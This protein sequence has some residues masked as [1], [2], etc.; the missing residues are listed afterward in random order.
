MCNGEW[1]FYS[2]AFKAVI[3]SLGCLRID[4][5]CNGN[6]PFILGASL[7]PWFSHLGA[8]AL[9]AREMFVVGWSVCL[10]WFGPPLRVSSWLQ[11]RG[12]VEPCFSPLWLVCASL[13]TS[14]LWFGYV[15]ANLIVSRFRRIFWVSQFV[16]SPW[17]C[18][19]GARLL[20]GRFQLYCVQY[21]IYGCCDAS[22]WLEAWF[23]PLGSL[24][25][26]VALFRG[27]SSSCSI[28]LTLSL[29]PQLSTWNLRI[30]ACS[31]SENLTY[32]LLWPVAACKILLGSTLTGGLLLP[33]I[34]SWL[35]KPDDVLAG[36]MAPFWRAYGSGP[37]VPLFVNICMIMYLLRLCPCPICRASILYA[38]GWGMGFTFSFS[39]ISRVL[40]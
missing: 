10:V 2:G 29:R 27:P 33:L 28:S 5:V 35:P 4:C 18:H 32:W 37:N 31:C 14:L 3:Q 36:Q 15:S 23:W 11:W 22:R 8:F 26:A 1:P 7:R 25:N 16:S 20:W 24:P 30:Q 17:F 12:S 34:F 9:V 13:E 21:A 38:Q 19:L 40:S 39:S 6:S